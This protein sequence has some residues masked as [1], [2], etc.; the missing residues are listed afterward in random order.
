MIT[1]AQPF[2][3]CNK[4]LHVWIKKITWH[5]LCL[6]GLPSS[7]EKIGYFHMYFTLY[8][9]LYVVLATV[10]NDREGWFLSP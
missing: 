3:L 9:V 6:P 4:V 5:G 7:W 1:G 8:S 10:V 2:S